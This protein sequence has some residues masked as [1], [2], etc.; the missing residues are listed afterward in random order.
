MHLNGPPPKKKKKK[1]HILRPHV[2][3]LVGAVCNIN[4]LVPLESNKINLALSCDRSVAR[5]FFYHLPFPSLGDV[6]VA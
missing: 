4:D 2:Q 6:A 3:V 5:H 1:N